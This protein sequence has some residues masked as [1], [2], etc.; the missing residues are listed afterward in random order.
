MKSV[1]KILLLFG[2]STCQS[3][4]RPMIVNMPPP[5]FIGA[6]KLENP[7]LIS[8]IPPIFTSTQPQ[9]SSYIFPS[10]AKLSQNSKAVLGSSPLPATS[11]ASPLQTQV[12]SQAP[13]MAQVPAAVSATISSPTQT[14]PPLET[15]QSS[16]PSSPPVSFFPPQNPN[17][18]I[19]I[20]GLAIASLDASGRPS[21]QT[22]V[23]VLYLGLTPSPSVQTF[24]FIFQLDEK[25]QSFFLTSRVTRSAESQTLETT[26][27]SND[28]ES[29]TRFAGVSL[30][31]LHKIF[32]FSFTPELVNPQLSKFQR[33]SRIEIPSKPFSVI[34]ISNPPPTTQIP[35]TSSRL[36]ESQ[37]KE[38][39][40]RIGLKAVT[41]KQ[42]RIALNGYLS[43]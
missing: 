34:P 33:I 40:K 22:L 2:L 5:V 7:T 21:S 19:D 18:Q 15:A 9:E 24:T 12:A 16:L 6:A 4:P 27:I 39:P 10:I 1:V 31:N 13:A 42:N 32:E 17:S 20:L 30:K 26:S 38:L 29:V 11:N 3:A 28:I 14:P 23:K 8:N 41:A 35:P 25:G 36:L 37:T 43:Q